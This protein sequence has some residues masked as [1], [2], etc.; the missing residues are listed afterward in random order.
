[1][2]KLIML[3]LLGLALGSQTL[4]AG[5]QGGSAQSFWERLRSKI[6]SL[7]PQKR[8]T[9]T[10]ATGGVRGSS[11]APED[12]YW[13]GEASTQAIASDELDSFKAAMKL[14]ESNDTA[15]AQS[16]FS[17]FIKKYPGSSLRKD[18]EQALALLKP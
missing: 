16:A 3:S 5:E 17:A 13:K 14:A 9:A 11:V 7:A 12:I 6:E 1:M 15:Q 2:R 8:V 10:N 4:H 18:A